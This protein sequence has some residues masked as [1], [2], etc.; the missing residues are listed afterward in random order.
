MNSRKFVKP[1]DHVQQ[2]YL[3][4]FWAS[5]KACAYLINDLEVVQN[6]ISVTLYNMLILVSGG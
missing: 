4:A 3:T 2:L 1:D 6:D 5:M